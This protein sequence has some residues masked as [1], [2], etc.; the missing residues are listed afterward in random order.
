MKIIVI[1][2]GAYGVAAAWAFQSRGHQITVLEQGLF[3]SGATPLAAGIISRQCW[4]VTDAHLVDRTQDF[5]SKLGGPQ[6]GHMEMR[7]D[8]MLRL[9]FSEKSA[10]ALREETEALLAAGFKIDLLDRDATLNKCPD[11]S[12]EGLVLSAWDPRDAYADPY[13]FVYIASAILSKKGVEFRTRAPVARLAL[14]GGRCSGVVLQDGE[15]LSADLVVMAAGTG[16]VKLMPASGLPLPVKAYRTQAAILQLGWAFPVICHDLDSGL[17]FRRES[18]TQMLVGDGTE[19]FAS[20]VDAWNPKAD[21]QFLEEL[22][23]RLIERVPRAGDAG[24]GRGWAGLCVATPDRRP[25][26]GP[27]PGVEGLGILCGDNGFGFMR[28]PALGEAFAA[29]LLGEPTGL[30]LSRH[31]IDRFRDSLGQDFPVQQGFNLPC[32]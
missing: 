11:L 22:T 10:A 9:A 14:S 3:A 7:V 26:L 13:G 18:H 2:S 30:D 5:Y 32:S 25:L 21:A 27:Y 17:Y 29:T 8:G 15:T 1:G 23:E 4:D 12:V 16:A 28:A 24:L 31:R 6:S 19:P 20:N